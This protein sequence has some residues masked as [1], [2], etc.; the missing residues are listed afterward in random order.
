MNA[1]AEINFRFNMT[2]PG[3]RISNPPGLGVATE[4]LILQGFP[5]NDVQRP[6]LLPELVF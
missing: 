5:G 1:Q 6:S 3:L 2:R 4:A